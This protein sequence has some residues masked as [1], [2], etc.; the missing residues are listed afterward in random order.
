MT[1]ELARA[2]AGIPV[3]ALWPLT[4][5]YLARSWP[6]AVLTALASAAYVLSPA[7]ASWQSLAL[8][9]LAPA[10][11]LV[12]WKA[13]PPVNGGEGHTAP[14]RLLTPALLALLLLAAATAALMD[15]DRA[16]EV[17]GD[18]LESDGVA[19]V[20]I[21]IT[22]CV[23]LGGSVVAWILT[24]FTSALEEE[25]ES[26]RVNLANGGRY[27]GWFERAVLFAFVVAGQPDAAAIA[28]AAKS[29]ARFPT[30]REGHEGFAEYF[31]I[32]SLA[33]LAL[34]VAAAVAV[35]AAL[36]AALFP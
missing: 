28:L 14:R 16:R 22:A 23:F 13:S 31:L 18:V 5:P 26:S 25:L 33:S 20:A 24:P 6:R 2:A 34:A 27:I 15:F 7:F 19:Y 35:R 10:T 9:A 1:D 4:L 30:L 12:L 36:G 21:G 17:L 3:A 11:T 32:G 29:F 8:L